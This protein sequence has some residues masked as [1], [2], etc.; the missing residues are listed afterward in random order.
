ME[1]LEYDIT[2]EGVIP[3][4]LAAAAGLLILISFLFNYA[5][6]IWL[7]FPLIAIGLI[8]DHLFQKKLDKEAKEEL[9]KGIKSR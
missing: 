9:L 5:V 2:L 7:T 1:V 3:Y 8:V 4:I 6:L